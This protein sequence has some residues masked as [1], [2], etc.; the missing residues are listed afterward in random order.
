MNKSA[1]MHLGLL[2]SMSLFSATSTADESVYDPWEPV[3]LKVHAFNEFMDEHFLRPAATGYMKYVPVPARRGVSNFFANIGD[4]SVLANNLLQFKLSAAANDTGRIM[5][6]T[7]IGLGGV[8]DVATSI[9]FIKND[10]DFGQTLGTWG[11]GPGPYVVL[12]LFGP[13]NLRD[14]FGLFADTATNPINHQDNIRIR[15]TAFALEQ[16]DRRVAGLAVDALMLGDPYI[17][18]REAYSAQRE[19]LVTDGEVD[20][21]WDDEWDGWD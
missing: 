13:S 8:L 1:V 2:L 10:E 11:V 7:T 17:F 19:Y 6:N 20:D 5:L 15:N 14:S 9:G 16:L 12:P 18:T 21:S 4:I 3:N